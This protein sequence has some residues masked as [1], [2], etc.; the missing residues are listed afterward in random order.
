MGCTIN[1]TASFPGTITIMNKGK[2]QPKK[3]L[4]TAEEFNRH[5]YHYLVGLAIATVAT[6][7]IVYHV[8]EKLNWVDAY[9]FSVVTLSTVGYGDIVPHTAFDKIFTTFYIF[10]GVGII[11]TFLSVSMRRRSE[12][13]KAK[14]FDIQNDKDNSET[15]SDM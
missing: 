15:T 13:F 14:R 2:I 6:G 11:T 10:I 4:T 9:Y 3:R 8:S 12:I 1:V 5:A 7:T